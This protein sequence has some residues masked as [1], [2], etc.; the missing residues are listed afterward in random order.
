MGSIELT[1]D[2]GFIC[3]VLNDDWVNARI[4]E[5]GQ[6][7]NVNEDAAQTMIDNGLVLAWVVNG[8]PTGFFWVHYLT[9]SIMQIHVNF[10]KSKL[11][12]VSG[13]GAAML[14]YLKQNAPASIKKFVAFVPIKYPQAYSFS[15][16]EGLIDEGLFKES[17]YSGD[18]LIDQ[19]ILGIKRGEI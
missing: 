4:S 5:D 2:K 12:Y 9:T 3:S 18:K 17:F 19:H 15:L 6:R 10:P 13:S 7:M 11:R 8:K 14:Q 16:R 1:K